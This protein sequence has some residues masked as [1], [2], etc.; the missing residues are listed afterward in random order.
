VAGLPYREIIAERIARPLGLDRTFVPERV[1]DL[2]PL[3]IGISRA[4]SIDGSPR[5]VREHYHPGW[6]SH[7]VVASTASDIVRF[8]DALF[9]G[10]LISQDSL[11]A[12]MSLVPVAMTRES[13]A[14]SPLRMAAPSYGLGLMG[15]PAS[16]WGLLVGHNGGGPCYSASAF[17]AVGLGGASVCAMGAI[18]DDFSTEEIVAAVLDRL[19]AAHS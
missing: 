10:R 2:A 6:V 17:H 18:E 16:P 9:G 14:S 5:D 13:A 11:E 4:L 19:S 12:M 15:D 3:A 7:G 8:L 1:W